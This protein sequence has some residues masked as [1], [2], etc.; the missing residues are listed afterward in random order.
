MNS[1]FNRNRG[2]LADRTGLLHAVR[3]AELV[4]LAIY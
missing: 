2:F 1:I 4:F 3:P